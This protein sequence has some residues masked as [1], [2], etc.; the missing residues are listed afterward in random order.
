M[1]FPCRTRKT[2]VPSAR[3]L[4]LEGFAAEPSRGAIPGSHRRL[5]DPRKALPARDTPPPAFGAR[6]V[7]SGS[8][9]KAGVL[10]QNWQ[11]SC[12]GKRRADGNASRRTRCQLASHTSPARGVG[13]HAPEPHRRLSAVGSSLI[14]RSGTCAKVRQASYPCPLTCGLSTRSLCDFLTFAACCD[15]RLQDARRAAGQASTHVH[16][17]DLDDAAGN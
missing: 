8:R 13:G 1:H 10:P 7:T 14:G 12:F 11:T 2:W 9:R 5:D 3:S 17:D 15:R 4:M 16:P 6:V